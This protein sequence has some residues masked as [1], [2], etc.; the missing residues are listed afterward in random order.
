MSALLGAQIFKQ[1]I[2]DGGY[3]PEGGMQALPDALSEIFK[4]HSGKML[5]SDQSENKDQRA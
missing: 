3:Y 5:F 4:E 2:L 1:F